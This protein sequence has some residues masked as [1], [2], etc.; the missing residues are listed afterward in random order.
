MSQTKNKVKIADRPAYKTL[1]ASTLGP[2]KFQDGE[3]GDTTYQLE[4]VTVDGKHN[5]VACTKGVYQDVEKEQLYRNYRVKFEL[6]YDQ[7][8]E[9]VSHINLKSKSEFL[10]MGFKQGDVV[11]S[12]V[13]L[14]QVEISLSPKKE[15]RILRAPSS[16]SSNTEG[17]M[18]ESL[19]KDAGVSSGDYLAGKYR[20]VEIRE[21]DGFKTFFVDPAVM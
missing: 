9:L 18:L 20:V 10:P 16:V 21:R 19:K 7:D 3:S 14:E 4:Y 13:D 15:L 1:E 11:G 2:P 6:L 12:E 8:A 17:E 5:K